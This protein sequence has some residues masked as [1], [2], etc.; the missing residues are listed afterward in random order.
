ML[1]LHILN[2]YFDKTQPH[3]LKYAFNFNQHLSLG[4]YPEF[5]NV[6]LLLIFDVV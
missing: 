5:V 4:F 1:T 2:V 3:Q 6:P